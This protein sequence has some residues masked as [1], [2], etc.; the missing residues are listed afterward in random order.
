M[1]S[2]LIINKIKQLKVAGF[3]EVTNHYT[4]QP[5]KT[6]LNGR[7]ILDVRDTKI[8]LQN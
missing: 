7:D 8:H 5:T 4:T 1:F 3:S 6:V 2:K